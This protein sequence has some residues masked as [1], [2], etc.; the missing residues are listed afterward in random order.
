MQEPLI[1][2]VEIIMV[3]MVALVTQHVIVISGSVMFPWNSL[4][5]ANVQCTIS[6]VVLIGLEFRFN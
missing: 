5:S 4:M 3:S 6:A 2:R 1:H